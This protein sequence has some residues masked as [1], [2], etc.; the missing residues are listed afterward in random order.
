[1]HWNHGLTA[2][3]LVNE[4]W[5][6]PNLVTNIGGKVRLPNL[7]KEPQVLKQHQHFCQVLPVFLPRNTEPSGSPAT[8]GE[9]GSM[10]QGKPKHHE[11]VSVDP[12]EVREKFHELLK[13]YSDI[14]NPKFRSY[15]EA[16]GP[17]KTKV[18]M[19]PVQP[20]QR[21]GRVPQYA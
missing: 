12:L 15:N 17:F 3:G 14:F 4:L 11:A 21:K 6:Q 19:S 7:T 1:M 9:C 10:V 20:T 16:L 5:P 13:Q 18:H 2:L 8:S